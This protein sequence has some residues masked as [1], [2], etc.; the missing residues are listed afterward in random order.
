MST[1][2]IIVYDGASNII[3]ILVDAYQKLRERRR[4]L[5]CAST[6]HDILSGAEPVLFAI[7][8]L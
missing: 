2:T 1:P 8:F 6:L 4:L 5:F 3:E 7:D